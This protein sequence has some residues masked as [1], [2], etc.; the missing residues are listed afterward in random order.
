MKGIL[1]AILTI[2]LFQPALAF[3]LGDSLSDDNIKNLVKMGNTAF[4]MRPLN[5][6][7]SKGTVFGIEAGLA[8]HGTDIK[9]LTEG[10]GQIPGFEDFPGPGYFPAPVVYLAVGV[11]FGLGLEVQGLYVPTMSGIGFYTFG[12][13]LFWATDEVLKQVPGIGTVLSY[14]P[15]LFLSPRFTYSMYSLTLEQ[16]VTQVDPATGIAANGKA[17]ASISGATYGG[18]LC[19]SFKFPPAMS[20]ISIELYSGAGFLSQ[21]GEATANVM[22]TPATPIPGGPAQVSQEKTLDQSSSALHYYAGLQF[23]LFLFA[24]T[25]EYDH[26]FD[27]DSYSGKLSLKF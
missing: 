23:K 1:I 4:A 11:P 3:E 12:G 2:V 22:V 18:N 25:G 24:L 5:G 26:L 7:S 8:A 19:L 13:N 27:R 17:D 14:I 10:T 15:G 6:A 9:D 16:T 20:P 21:S